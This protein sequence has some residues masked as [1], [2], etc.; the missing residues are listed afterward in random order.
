MH[1]DPG[2]PVGP[3]WVKDDLHAARISEPVERRVDWASPHAAFS[4]GNGLKP[5]RNEVGSEPFQRGDVEGF[6]F[7]FVYPNRGASLRRAVAPSPFAAPTP[8]AVTVPP[9]FPPLFGG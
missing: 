7:L 4:A 6:L 8:A 5:R 3:P 1:E 2:R 9:T